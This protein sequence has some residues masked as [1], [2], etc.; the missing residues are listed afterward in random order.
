MVLPPTRDK[1]V[2]GC[3]A[4]LHEAAPRQ[5]RLRWCGM[6][7]RTRLFATPTRRRGCRQSLAQKGG[8]ASARRAWAECVAPECV[9]PEHGAPEHG[10]PGHAVA[11]HPTNGRDAAAV[12][13][14]RG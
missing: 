8:P 4:E 7:Q 9:A 12:P 2:C 1:E 3:H 5:H 13:A 10:A 11:A 6:E 14:R